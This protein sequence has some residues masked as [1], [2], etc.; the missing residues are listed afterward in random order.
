MGL[1]SDKPKDPACAAER[2]SP[3]ITESEGSQEQIPAH[4]IN[5][6]PP[7]LEKNEFF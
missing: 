7:P 6:K 3:Q 1:I 4:K 2:K 5:L